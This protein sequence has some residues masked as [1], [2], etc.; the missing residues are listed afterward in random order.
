MN[1]LD[2]VKK[3]MAEIEKKNF[4]EAE[5]FISDDFQFAGAVPQPIGRAQWLELHKA[6]ANAFP[7]LSFNASGFREENGKVVGQVQLT[8]THTRDFSVG[9]MGVDSVPATNKRITMPN[10][11]IEVTLKNDKITRFDVT[12]VAGGGLQGLLRQL[13]VKTKEEAYV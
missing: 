11:R 13:G 10:E 6:L 5:K 8:G 7:D 9:Q 12:Q 3:F 1:A 2:T 4:K